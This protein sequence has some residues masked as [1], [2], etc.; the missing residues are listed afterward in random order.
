MNNKKDTNKELIDE[1]FEICRNALEES[2]EKAEK[3]EGK[4]LEEFNKN[5]FDFIV[6]GLHPFAMNIVNLKKEGIKNE[7]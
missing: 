1:M 7:N 5:T 3:L 6:N 4:E 2:F